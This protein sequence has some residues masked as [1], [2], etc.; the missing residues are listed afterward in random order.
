MAPSG[1]QK[2]LNEFPEPGE[3]TGVPVAERLAPAPAP[4]ELLYREHF[5]FVWR[6]A[7]RLGC[8]EDWLDDAVHE[9][10]LVATRRLGEFEGRS[11]IRTWL[12]AIT[13]RVV[14]RM[15]RDRSR[16]RR[17]TSRY[18]TEQP[19]LVSDAE[20]ETEAA[21]YLRQLLLKLSEPQRVVLILAELE[22]FTS[23]EIAGTLGVPA[24]TVDSRLRAAR[25]QL[26]RTLE[27]DRVRD[28]RWTR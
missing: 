25:V 15:Q 5:A 1:F 22:G 21:Q 19:E 23:L 27:R 4:A 28:E 6:N 8:T 11:S 7:R 3:Q 20:R 2:S 14:G 12:F 24:G 18:V 10:F 17:Q 9:V 26:A 16:Q 13:F